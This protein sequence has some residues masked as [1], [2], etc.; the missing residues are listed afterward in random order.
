MTDCKRV[1]FCGSQWTDQSVRLCLCNHV[2]WCQVW[3]TWMVV[4]DSGEGIGVHL[5][6]A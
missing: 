2:G 1:A 6:C 3:S 4:D 5:C